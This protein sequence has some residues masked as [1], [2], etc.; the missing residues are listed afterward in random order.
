VRF[1]QFVKAPAPK[2]IT[3]FGK[4]IL[5]R[6]EH[7]A[8]AFPPIVVTPEGITRLIREVQPAKAFDPIE[9]MDAGN[10]IFV[11][12][13]QPAKLKLPMFVTPDGISTEVTLVLFWNDW[14]PI[15]VTVNPLVPDG[16][17]ASPSIEHNTMVRLFKLVA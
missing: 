14:S 5:D 7:P 9:M 10:T 4:V 3:L 6:L 1:G 13:K 11:S 15:E 12:F 8:K 16:R 2:V 17:L